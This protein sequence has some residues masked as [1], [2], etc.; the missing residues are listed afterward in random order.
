[1]IVSR[2]LLQH[3]K[4]STQLEEVQLNC[5]FESHHVISN[6]NLQTS[7]AKELKLMRF[8]LSWKVQLIQ[9]PLLRM[10]RSRLD[11]VNLYHRKMMFH[12]LR[13]VSIPTPTKQN[14]RIIKHEVNGICHSKDW[15]RC[16]KKNWSAENNRNNL[17]IGIQSHEFMFSSF[18]VFSRSACNLRYENIG[19]WQRA[20][21]RH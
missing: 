12:Y 19:T 4:D 2:K 6:L 3:L 7:K 18:S 21:T 8:H 15:L 13:V 14:N 20:K 16:W 9:A 11:C 5:G 10:E 1:M 17:N